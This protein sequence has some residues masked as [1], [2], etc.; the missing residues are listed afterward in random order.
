MDHDLLTLRI[1][2]E[3]W[4]LDLTGADKASSVQ[5]LAER[6]AGLDIL[7]EI[8]Y[9]DAREAAAMQAVARAG[10]R[11]PV[12]AFSRTHGE[13]RQMG[14]SRLER[15]EPWLD[16][17]SPAEGLWYKGFLYQGFDET[18]EGLVEFC[19]LPD[20]LAAQFP[21]PESV[22]P[23]P[24]PALAPA[25]SP[26]EITPANSSAVD[27][28]TTLLAFA[29]RDGLRVDEL[30]PLY[31]YLQDATPGRTALLLALGLELEHLRRTDNGLK[32][33]RTSLSWLKESRESQLRILADAWRTSSWNELCRTPGLS[34]EGSGWSNDPLLARQALLATLPRRQDWFALD[35]LTDH[36]KETNPDF[37]RPDGNYDTWYIRDVAG[38]AFIT[39]FAH[40]HLVEGRLLR[41]LVRGPLHWL[42]M[43]D[44]GENCFRLTERGLAWLKGETPAGRGI[45]V[46]LVVQADASLLVPHNAGR[47]Q[48]FQAARI[49]DPRPY[50]PAKP[51][52]YQITPRSLQ[53]AQE[54]GIDPQR[55]ISF[56][57]KAGQRTVPTSTRRAIERWQE[58]G[59][60]GRLE[61][62]VILRVR[63]AEILETLQNNPKTQPYLGE[64]LGD[65]A[66]IISRKD[67]PQL[68]HITAQLGLL[69]DLVE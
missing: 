69:L 29:Q 54:A 31:P 15:E 40:W 14:Q 50:A 28:V 24:Q 56:L 53:R 32:P 18:E 25:P 35:D 45:E 57:E 16:P 9:I 21:P 51:Y 65:L 37:Q 2:G 26:A 6:L 10:G 36:I 23:E 49:A 66:V 48:R 27:D 1:I 63:D 3:W 4:E 8:K 12:S 34:C 43:V 64:R 47:Y 33:S 19:F 7:E 61:Q 30:A 68:Q 60:E 62:V 58:K 52:L 42:G 20:E 11:I 44:L 46:P 5:A 22:T 17:I 67:W 41:F 38:D 13:V 39:G 55:V 59:M